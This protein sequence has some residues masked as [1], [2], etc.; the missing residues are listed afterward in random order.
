M[1]ALWMP[2]VEIASAIDVRHR[3]LTCRASAFYCGLSEIEIEIAVEIEK[4]GDLDFDPDFD[5]D[6]DF[7]FDK[8]I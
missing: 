6:P 1:Q 5:P 7:D 4:V 3:L 2:G 8:T